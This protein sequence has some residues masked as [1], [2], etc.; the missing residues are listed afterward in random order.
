MLKDLNED[1]QKLEEFMSWISEEGRRP[2]PL[3]VWMFNRIINA[4]KD[5][6]Q[7]SKLIKALT[8]LLSHPKIDVK[9]RDEIKFFVE[10]Q[11]KSK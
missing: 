9:I 11:N 1:E 5:P 3:T 8:N 4:E 7:K 6:I 10:F 2:S